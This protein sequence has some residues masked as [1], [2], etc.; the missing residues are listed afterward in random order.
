MGLLALLPLPPMALVSSLLERRPLSSKTAPPP[1]NGLYM[2]LEPA[3]SGVPV[4]VAG[5]EKDGPDA[6]FVVLAA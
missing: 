5:G 1:D 6:M 4:V 3:L 2:S